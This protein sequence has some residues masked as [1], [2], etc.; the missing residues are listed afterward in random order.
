MKGLKM[1]LDP[2]TFGNTPAAIALAKIL[3]VYRETTGDPN[4]TSKVTN[5]LKRY[6]DEARFLLR[7]QHDLGPTPEERRQTEVIREKLLVMVRQKAADT[8]TMSNWPTKVQSYTLNVLY[9]RHSLSLQKMK[10]GG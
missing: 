10:A 9:A 8:I 4:L 3:D 2:H 7:G 5:I 1:A 6:S